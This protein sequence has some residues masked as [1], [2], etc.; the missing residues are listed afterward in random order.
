M[1]KKL[2]IAIPTYNFAE[3]LSETLDTIVTQARVG[4]VEILILDG[5]STDHTPNLIKNYQRY[6]NNIKY[7]RLAER[8]GIDRDMAKAVTCASGD[9]CWL[10]SGD[11]LMLPGALAMILD[12]IQSGCDLYL[13]RH[14]EWIDYEGE[15]RTWPTVAVSEAKIFNL[16]NIGERH[17]YFVCAETTEAF[18]GFIGGLVVRRKTWESVLLSEEFIGSCWAHVARLFEIMPGG[19]SVK[20]LRDA[21]LRRRPDND[22]FGSNSITRRF[23]LTIEGFTKIVNRFYGHESF[24][25]QQVRRVL[26]NEYHPLNMWLGKYLCL[27]DP[28][29]EDILLMDRLLQ[30]LYGDKS[31]ASWKVRF[32][33]ACLTPDRFRR[34][35]PELSAKYDAI[36][37][38]AP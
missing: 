18:F 26:R 33:Y 3:Y 4:E 31:W 35:Q 17:D 25:A 1:T 23:Q 37:K 7:V 12:E 30:S 8:G 32:N 19:L 28:E 34:W 36:K 20:V 27:I 11:D 16:S 22:S 38:I 13:T 5:A 29:G 10:F 21:Y 6:F 15:W 14:L 24:E 2:S 9:Y